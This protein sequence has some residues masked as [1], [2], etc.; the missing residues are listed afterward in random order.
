MIDVREMF[1]RA[2]VPVVI[3]VFNQYTYLRQM[4]ES[5][6]N[7]DFKSIVI[8][9]QA[10]EFSVLNEYLNQLHREKR[11]V[12]IKLPENYGPHWFYIHK[13]YNHMVSPLIY[14]DPDLAFPS[15]LDGAFC[16]RLFD[17]TK[18]YQV[19]KA[20]CALDISRPDLFIEANW[21]AGERDWNILEWEQQFWSN[22]IDENV[23]E[24]DIDTTFHLF[25]LDFYHGDNFFRAV[26]LSGE[27][28]TMK[29]LPWYAE[30]QITVE[31]A[32]FYKHRTK[33]SS[34]S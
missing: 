9:D 8:L 28:F 23:Y 15:K 19:A 21:R 31:E 11:A 1:L 17:A 22:Q 24:A 2:T 32:E 33:Y 20:G 26:R 12:I 4:I 14:T 29:H 25:N 3:N 6:E 5:L 13:I 27:G 10:S 34:W 7:N 18:I 30:K 16:S